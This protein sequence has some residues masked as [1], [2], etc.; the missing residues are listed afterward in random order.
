MLARLDTDHDGK[1]STAELEAI[2]EQFRSRWTDADKNH[3]GFVDKAEMAA[4][5]ARGPR[6]GGGGPGGPEGGG[7]GQ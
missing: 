3:D 5:P 4:M 7:P 1:L 2:P 6:P